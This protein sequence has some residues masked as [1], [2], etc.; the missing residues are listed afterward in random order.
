MGRFFKGS[1]AS[2]GPR[3]S[4]ADHDLAFHRLIDNE[5]EFII[6]CL[7]RF[8]IRPADTEDVLQE[9]LHAVY[10][11]FDQYDATRAKLRTWLYGIVFF[12]SQTFLRRAHHQREKFG[13]ELELAADAAPDPEKQ[14]IVTDNRRVVLELIEALESNQRAVF[15]A[16]EIREMPMPAI[17]EALGIA[18]STGW[19]RLQQARQAFTKALVIRQAREDFAG[20][21]ARYEIGRRNRRM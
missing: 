3:R 21:M 15:I 5:L 20:A 19:S 17:S 9:V 13:I 18:E 1:R 7:Q 12:Q 8:G 2:E 6:R 14:T 10:R 4:K 11:I 16:Y